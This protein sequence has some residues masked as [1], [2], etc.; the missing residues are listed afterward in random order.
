MIDRLLLAEL[1]R[2]LADY[3]AVALLGPRQCGKTTLAQSL[4]G[5]YFD[6]EQE[7]ERLRL[8]LEW[9]DRLAQPERL[10]LDE[11]QAWP[12]I[13]ARLRSA[14]DRDRKRP[15]RF[16]LLGSVAPALVARAS[17]SLAG[18]LS[19]LELTPFLWPELTTERR[20]RLWLCGGYPDGGVLNERAFPRWQL[21]YLALLAQRDLPA[22]GLPARP[23]VTDRL[24]RLLA[25][26]HGQV[27]NASRLGQSL[28]LSYH[29]VN[30][31]LDFLAG[32]FLIRRLP[33]FHAN[34]GKRLVRSPKVYWRDSGLL[35]A[36]WNV[37]D[38]RSLL[39]Q[40]WV[41]ASWEG[42]VIEQVLG[43]LAS[44]GRRFEPYFFRTSDGHELDLVLD[45]GAERWAIEVK[46][47]A[48]PAPADMERLDRT[49][50]MIK[51]RRRFLVSQTPRSSGDAERASC[52]L[53]GLID[54]LRE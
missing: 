36:L 16:L 1:H 23:Q 15:G 12:E 30:S 22:W 43:E 24:L 11:A 53:V 20:R 45:L 27:W 6:L 44:Q 35:H 8:D 47:T 49:A 25:A 50:T 41:G 32:A 5:A 51:A 10:V 2:R 46:L 17:E 9:Q 18:R 48:S 28:G 31:Y 29:T 33:P 13:F 42:F 37:A 34:L 39:V 7:P 3:P 4:G 26:V 38:D 21:D 54:R 52:N 19:Q 14:I 40:P